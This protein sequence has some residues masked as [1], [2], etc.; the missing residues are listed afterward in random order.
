[1]AQGQDIDANSTIEADEALYSGVDQVIPDNNVDL[2][3]EAKDDDNDDDKADH[4]LSASSPIVETDTQ[5]TNSA[6]QHDSNDPDTVTPSLDKNVLDDTNGSSTT[7]AAIP[8]ELPSPQSSSSIPSVASNDNESV[9]FL[10]PNLSQ[11]TEFLDPVAKYYR[12]KSILL[13]GATGFI[14]KSV[15]WKLIHSLG[16]SIGCIYLLVR[17][18]NNK[19]SKMGRPNDRIKSELWNNK[20]TK[21]N[22]GALLYH[23]PLISFFLYARHSYLSGVPWANPLLTPLLE[24]RSFLSAAILSLRTCLWRMRTAKRWWQT[25]RSCS[26]VLPLWIVTNDWI[27]L[28]R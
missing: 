1:M 21:I 28:W 22:I 16:Q 12:N 13:T 27:Y 15:L 18:G 23:E 7:E 19:R 6:P 8:P 26:I 14:G 3:N 2:E 11:D 10:S 17:S 9:P 24:T 4:P 25:S 20:V 5:T